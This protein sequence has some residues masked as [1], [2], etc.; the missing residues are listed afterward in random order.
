MK[1]EAKPV[2]R[3]SSLITLVLMLACAGCATSV[4]PDIV[5]GNSLT[6][7]HAFTDATARS[8]QQN[9]DKVCAERKQAAE[10][11]Q[12]ACSMKECTTHYVCVDKN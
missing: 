12:S 8:A 7:H 9:A 4:Q 2:T 3:H 10:K 1:A 5:E 11:V 6:Y